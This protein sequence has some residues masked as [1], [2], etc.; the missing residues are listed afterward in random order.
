MLGAFL[1]Q[2]KLQNLRGIVLHL[3]GINIHCCKLRQQK[4]ALL[5]LRHFPLRL[6]LQNRLCRR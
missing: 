3:R 1:K 6:R 4:I 2:R 5:Q